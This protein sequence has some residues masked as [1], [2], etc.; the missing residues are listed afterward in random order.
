VTGLRT[1]T[2]S[3]HRSALLLTTSA[4]AIPGAAFQAKSPQEGLLTLVDSCLH[5]TSTH[6]TEPG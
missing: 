2:V 6:Y 4:I 3:S 1:V 5:L